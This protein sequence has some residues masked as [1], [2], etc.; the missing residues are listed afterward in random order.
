MIPLVK[1]DEAV[2]PV[3]PPNFSDITDMPFLIVQVAIY[4]FPFQQILLGIPERTDHEAF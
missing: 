1:G 4:E 3:F 2:K